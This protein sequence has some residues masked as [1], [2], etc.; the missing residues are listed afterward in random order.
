MLGSPKSSLLN[1]LRPLVTEAYLIHSG[2]SYR[3][4]P[5]IFRLASGVVD[6]WPLPRIVR[7]FSEQLAKRTG[8]SVLL[9]VMDADKGL[10]T[11]VDLVHSPHPIRYQ[12]AVGTVRP[13]YDSA[14]GRVHL[15]YGPRVWRQDYLAKAQF[16]VRTMPEVIVA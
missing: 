7:P 2:G 13:L 11:Y 15:A 9:S 10:M 12:V 3:L 16:D 4:G 5:S 6:V 14:A 8:E 1:L